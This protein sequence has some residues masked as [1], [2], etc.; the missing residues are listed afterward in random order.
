M[1]RVTL[2]AKGEVQRVGYRDDVERVARK[3]NITG[4]VENQKPYDVKIVAEGEAAV[5]DQFIERIKI[6]RFPI[7]VEH[8]EVSFGDYKGDFEYFEIRRGKWQE[9]FGERLDIAGRLFYRNIELS[10]RSVEL[11][12]RNVELSERSVELGER[13]VALSERSVELGERN[14]ALSER[15]VELGE[16]N[17]ALIE[18]SVELGERN[19][20]LGERSVE[21]GERNVALSERSVELGE[22][23]VALSERSVELGERNVALI[24]R[25]VE[26]GERNVVL[27]EESVSIGKLMLDKQDETITELKGVRIDLKSYMEERFERIEREIAAIK[28]KIGVV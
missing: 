12:E 27:G 8:V 6:N 22:R 13:N 7:D 11:G 2:I 24:E 28:D 21:L 14:V 20:V 17:V 23:N 4:Y 5:I 9:E 18:R 3:L 10:E 15:S 16:R 26:L 1:Q 19:V 25:S